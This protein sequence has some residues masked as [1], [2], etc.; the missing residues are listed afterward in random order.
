MKQ[1]VFIHSR[2][3]TGVIHVWHASKFNVQT[4]SN[5]DLKRDGTNVLYIIDIIT[6]CILVQ[7]CIQNVMRKIPV[8]VFCQSHVKHAYRKNNI[9]YTLQKSESH[10]SKPVQQIASFRDFGSGIREY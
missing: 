2:E 8:R 7:Y 3:T 5:D 4:M 9:L 1:E 6:C 10:K